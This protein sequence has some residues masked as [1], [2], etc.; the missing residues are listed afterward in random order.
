VL[1]SKLKI[2]SIGSFTTAAFYGVAGILLLVVMSLSNF[3]PHIALLG[4]TSIIAAY[5][6]LKRRFWSTWL[7]SALFF[8]VTA[9]T[10]YTA[11]Y[12]AKFDSLTT[13]AM[14]AYLVL[15]WIF[16]AYAVKTRPKPE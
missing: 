15:T 6:I 14:I 3:P 9:L 13:T 10:L 8:V 4:I 16:T 2:E 7:I 5:G 1:S 11:Y 12:T